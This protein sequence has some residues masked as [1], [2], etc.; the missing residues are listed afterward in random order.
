MHG[1][2]NKIRDNKTFVL[3]EGQVKGE[4]E[5]GDFLISW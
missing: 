3:F 4:Y 1:Q 2:G 5:G